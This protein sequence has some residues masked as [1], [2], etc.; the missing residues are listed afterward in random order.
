MTRQLKELIRCGVC[1][2]E[3]ERICFKRH[4]SWVNTVRSTCR[5]CETEYRQGWYERSGVVDYRAGFND[6]DLPEG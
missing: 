1:K 4:R 3:K 6:D 5:Q 2:T